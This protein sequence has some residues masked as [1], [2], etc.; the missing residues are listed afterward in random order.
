MPTVPTPKDHSTALV[1]RDTLE[2]ES[3]VTVNLYIFGIS[4]N[5]YRTVPTVSI[6]VKLTNMAET[7]NCLWLK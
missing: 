2:M 7:V 5:K 6:S 3:F 1:I 4:E